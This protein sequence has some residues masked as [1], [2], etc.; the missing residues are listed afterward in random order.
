[1]ADH[2]QAASAVEGQAQPSRISYL[3][4]I[5][6]RRVVRA[7][8]RRLIEKHGHLNAIN[9]FPVPDGDT[10][11]NMAGTMKSI[12]AS[13]SATP[14]SSIGRM[15][16]IVAESALMGA[17][18]NSGVILA[19]FLAGFSE[20]VKD[21]SRVSPRDFAEAAS[22]AARRAVEAI[23]H[24]KEGTILTVIRDWAEHL[25][26][27]CHSYKDFHHLLHDSLDRARQSV[28]ET[29]E[30]LAALKAADVVDAGGLG[31][32]YLLEGIAEFTER[33]T[34][35]RR[36]K[37]DGPAETTG[38]VGAQDGAQADSATLGEAQERVAVEELT[39]G[40][41][42]ECLIRSEAASPVDR[43]ELRC[44]LEQL[45]D[46]IVVAGAGAV[47]RVHVHTD[48]P[49]TVFAIAAEYGAVSHHKAE[50]MLRQHRDLLAAVAGGHPQA[51]PAPTGTAVVTDSTCDLPRELLDQYGIRT[52]PLR[53]F[54]DDE[55]Y[56]DKVS[57]SVDEF[58]RR[59]PSSRSA[60]TSQPAPAD[61]RTVY[62]EVLRTHAQVA[63][64]HVTAMYSGTHQSAATVARMVSPHIAA[65]D[66]RTLTVG[67]G[68][69]VLEAAR[70]AQAGM[71]AAEVARLAARDADN[72]HVYVS[73]ETL[74]FAVRG[75]RMSRGTG[76]VAKLLHIKPVLCFDPRKGGKVDVA[77][78][79]IGPR[80]AGEKLFALLERAA[81]NLDNPR[82][83]V[84]HVGAPDTA[85][86]YAKELEARFGVAPLYVVPASPVLGCHSGP[87][88]CAVALLGDQKVG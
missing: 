26:E 62:E 29:R 72:L 5:R 68:L 12:V 63:S 33:G 37:T 6:F 76:M 25:R 87:G 74:D 46:S 17:R 49:D 69:V 42:T 60:R 14:E 54:L 80:R 35:N 78:K 57:I 44:R 58:N 70:R 66:C 32:V 15:S 67:L 30:K 71:D 88:A 18:G 65:V 48:T 3:D 39:Y 79:G 27:N 51:A 84:A 64:L 10:G 20:G 43:E 61:F 21:L 28:Q 1:M 16:S 77:A 23:A 24:P 22:L 4:G 50:D 59:L 13:T 2:H 81:A 34:L 55:E 7:A 52:V 56:V 31:F 75:G 19:Q 45:G 86:R 40:Y 9:V 11:S 73:M 83:A 38:A 53:L 41:C 47:T 82:F 85:A 8:A 36:G